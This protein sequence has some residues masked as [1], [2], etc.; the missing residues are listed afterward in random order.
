MTLM[1]LDLAA[2]CLGNRTESNQHNG[3]GWQVVLSCYVV[4]NLEDQVGPVLGTGS[5]HLA[6]DHQPFATVDIDGESTDSSG[7]QTSTG[8]F[9]CQ[10]DVLRVSIDTADNDQVLESPGHKQLTVAH[11]SQIACSQVRSAVAVCQLGTESLLRLFHSIPVAAT[12]ALAMDPDFADAA[13]RCLAV[14]LSIHH[15]HIIAW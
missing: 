15:H 8:L 11:E 9:H 10:F 2:G 3:V 4:A 14:G 12:D 5:P 6:D 7:L 1:P 13:R